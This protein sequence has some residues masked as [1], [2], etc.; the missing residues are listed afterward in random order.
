[1][2]KNTSLRNLLLLLSSIAVSQLAGFLGSVATI[3]NIPTWYAFLNKPPFNPPNWLFAPVWTTLFTLMGISLFLV[4][5]KQKILFSRPVKIFLIHLV[6]NAFWSIVFFGLKQLGLA[7]LVIIALW[8]MI[9]YIIKI[10]YKIDKRA[11]YLLYPYLAW[12]SFASIL[13]FS[14]WLLNL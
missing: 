12:V 11:S 7:F 13:N 3:K 1:M 5:K 14:L 9:F 4:I 6:I 8:A 10:F 2:T